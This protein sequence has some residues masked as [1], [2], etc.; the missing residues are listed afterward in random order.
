[1]KTG[2]PIPLKSTIQ[3]LMQLDVLGPFSLGGGT[4]L[5]LKYNHRLRI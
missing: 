5:V 1:M 4:N 3:E 2:V